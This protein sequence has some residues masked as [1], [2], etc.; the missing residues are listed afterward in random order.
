MSSKY[1]LSSI[2]LPLVC[3]L[4]FRTPEY[5]SRFVENPRNVLAQAV[6]V[7]PGGP[8]SLKQNIRMFETVESL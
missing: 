4:F 5:C 1:P 2:K 8:S 7:A 3:A 6:F